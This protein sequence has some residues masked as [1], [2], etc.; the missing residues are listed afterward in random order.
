[1]EAAHINRLKGLQA[2]ERQPQQ[3][4]REGWLCLCP[5]P[6]PPQSLFLSLC[7]SDP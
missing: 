6:H 1:M 5:Q 4:K 2:A 3:K 7:T